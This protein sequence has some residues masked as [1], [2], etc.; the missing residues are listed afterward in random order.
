MNIKEMTCRTALT[1]SKLPGLDYTLNP[2]LG[3]M[4]QCQYCYA[5]GILH[6]NRSQWIETVAVKRN[7]PLILSKELKQKKPGI[8]GLSTVTDPYQPIE[9]TYRV[10]RYCIEV[11]IHHNFPVCIQTKSDLILQD[12]ELITSLPDVEVIVSIG[13][14]DDTHRKLLEPGSSSIPGRLR[15]LEAFT[16]TSVKTSVFF[17]PIYPTITP[18]QIPEI[19]DAF[20]KTDVDEIMIDTLHL[21]QDIIPTLSRVFKKNKEFSLCLPLQKNTL[22]QQRFFDVRKCIYDYIKNKDITVKD[23]F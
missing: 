1:P 16:D 19:I 18:D 21:K 3:C 5:P 8:I 2:Y 17:G 6:L 23:A 7:L 4:H 9:K 11:L 12:K 15:I 22:I 13:T 14:L 10:T 20:L